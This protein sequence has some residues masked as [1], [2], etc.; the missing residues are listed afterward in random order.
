MPH[1][2]WALLFL[3]IVLLRAMSVYGRLP[4]TETARG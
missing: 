2:V 1:Q 4:A 3:G